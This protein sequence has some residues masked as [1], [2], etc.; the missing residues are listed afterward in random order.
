HRSRVARVSRS[1]TTPSRKRAHLARS[2]YAVTPISPPNFVLPV[3]RAFAGKEHAMRLK[4]ISG[5]SAIL[6][7]LASMLVSAQRSQNSIPNLYPFKNSAGWVQ[8]FTSNGVLDLNNPFFQELGRNG[9]TCASCH[10]PDQAWSIG[11]DKVQA[12][13]DSTSGLDPIFRINDGS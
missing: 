1:I 8:T 6:V 5:L 10:L 3:E 2:G 7:A 12:R 4:T 11:A 9:R 13:F